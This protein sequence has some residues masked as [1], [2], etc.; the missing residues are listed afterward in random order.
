MF[1]MSLE[2]NTVGERLSAFKNLKVQC[3]VDVDSWQSLCL[4]AFTSTQNSVIWCNM[5]VSFSGA[6]CIWNRAL[7]FLHGW[8][9]ATARKQTDILKLEVSLGL[10]NNLSLCQ[11]FLKD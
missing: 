8:T 3:N 7:F 5:Q 6:Y 10:M 2:Y 4:K 1:I 9:W 11:T